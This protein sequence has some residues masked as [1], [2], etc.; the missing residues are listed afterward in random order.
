MCKTT[1]ESAANS[2]FLSDVLIT[3]GAEGKKN[4]NLSMATANKEMLA[5]CKAK[6]KSGTN[7]VSVMTSYNFAVDILNAN[8]FK[9]YKRELYDLS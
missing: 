3:K 9:F 7:A 8:G 5:I 2:N 4:N 6:V 1:I